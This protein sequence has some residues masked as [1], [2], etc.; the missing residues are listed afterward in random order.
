PG[1]LE[2]DAP[3]LL[4][5]KP[6]HGKPA[7]IAFGIAYIGDGELKITGP[8]MVEHFAEKFPG[9]FS[10]SDNRARTSIRLL[11]NAGRGWRFVQGGCAHAIARIVLCSETRNGATISLE[12]AHLQLK[13]RC[14]ADGRPGGRFLTLNR[15]N[16]ELWV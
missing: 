6:V 10:L 12:T 14:G 1:F 5:I 4:R 7:K 8:A 11:R 2:C 13:A 9:A 15:I 16:I 3:A